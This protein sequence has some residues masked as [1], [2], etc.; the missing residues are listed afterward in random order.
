[1]G[2]MMCV[3]RRVILSKHKVRSRDQ[4]WHLQREFCLAV[5]YE[6]F[7]W[8]AMMVIRHRDCKLLIDTY[9]LRQA[10]TYPMTDLMFNQM[11]PH[12]VR[13]FLFFMFDLQST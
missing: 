2:C 12:I 13:H 10:R 7:R 1:M 11:E 8:S 6:G 4:A 5:K 9:K 3:G